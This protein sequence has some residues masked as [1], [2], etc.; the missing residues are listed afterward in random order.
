MLFLGRITYFI[1]SIVD[2]SPHPLLYSTT[3]YNRPKSVQYLGKFCEYLRILLL[4]QQSRLQI[5]NIQSTAASFVLRC[6]IFYPHA[7]KFPLIQGNKLGIYPSA[8][9]WYIKGIFSLKR[10]LFEENYLN[11]GKI[12]KT[13]QSQLKRWFGLANLLPVSKTRQATY[14]FHIRSTKGV[15]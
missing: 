11:D 5:Y 4:S 13:K 3:I 1:L 6:V 7:E 9:I 15:H 10:Y 2:L 8:D 12:V 14:Y